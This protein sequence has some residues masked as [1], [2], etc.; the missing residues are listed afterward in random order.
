MKSL[1]T[2]G[3]QVPIKLQT[4]Y[5][6]AMSPTQPKL[7]TRC[8]SHQ[9]T[10]K[11]RVSVI[12]SAA[13]LIKKRASSYEINSICHAVGR[14]T[15]IDKTTSDTDLDGDFDQADSNQ[16]SAQAS[17]LG[18]NSNKLLGFSQTITKVRGTRTLA[19]TSSAVNYALDANGNLTSD[20]L[21]AFDYDDEIGRAHV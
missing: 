21:R 9:K 18:A 8:P 3:G 13:S 7:R 2:N 19:T 17:V 20:G 14:F 5:D 16:T 15:S 12:K 10:S 1:G 11:R 4:S 6:S